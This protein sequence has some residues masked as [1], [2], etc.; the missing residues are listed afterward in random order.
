MWDQTRIQGNLQNGI[1]KIINDN[2]TSPSISDRK[3][4]NF[5][6]RA[7][8]DSAITGLTIDAQF[9]GDNILTIMQEICDAY[10]IGFKVTLEN[11]QFVFQLYKGVDRSYDQTTNPFVIFSKN[12]ENIIN[13]NYLETDL[14]LKNLALVAGEDH[15]QNRKTVTV[16]SVSGLERK[17]LYVDARDIQSAVD[18]DSQTEYITSISLSSKTQ[19]GVTY[20]NVG[21]GKVDVNG[22]PTGYSYADLFTIPSIPRGVYDFSG[23]PGYDDSPHYYKLELVGV[24]GSA[25]MNGNSGLV[26]INSTLTNV[27]VRASISV[28]TAGEEIRSSTFNPKLKLY[29][30]HE[31]D[32]KVLLNERGVE[33]LAEH[34]EIKTF[35]GQMET[36]QLFKY[37]EDFFM[38][39]IVQVENEFL[40]K[41]TARVVE[42]VR[43][44]SN[45]GVECYPTFKAL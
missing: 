16:G 32:Y 22:T 10:S 15:A 37:Q 39:D 20:S 38:G 7:S 24:A 13:S 17:E 4:S 11:N 36:T 42:F 45:N 43:S 27:V 23:V 33:K 12:F 44:F 40:L 29:A 34:V 26:T 3:I 30:L 1:Q 18:S 41:G 2:F 8:T 35:E 5:V 19:A 25:I 28:K 6:F 31:T 9:T 14:E 21:D